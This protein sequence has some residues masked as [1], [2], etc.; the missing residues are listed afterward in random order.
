MNYFKFKKY[1]DILNAHSKFLS[2]FKKC[3]SV[4]FVSFREKISI[5]HERSTHFLDSSTIPVYFAART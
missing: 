3:V 4:D 1:T 2:D 5:R